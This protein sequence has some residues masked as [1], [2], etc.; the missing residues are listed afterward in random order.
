M[1]SYI[2]QMWQLAIDGQTQGIWFFAAL[3]TLIVC[4]YSLIF[5]IRTRSWPFVK[6]ELLDS[7]IKK[8][9]ATQWVQSEQD[10]IS[11]ALYKYNVSGVSYEGTKISPW[12]VVASHNAK[13]ILKKQLAAIERFVDGKIK[14]FYNPNNPKKS[15][16]LI[17][18][19]IGISI[20]F[21][22]AV[23][24]LISFYFKYQ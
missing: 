17:A 5:Q 1:I 23:L 4:S 2:E 14:V 19:K 22:I 20:T 11:K 7:G 18:G 10:Y 3:Y 16:L 8:F 21:A 6:G 13:F 15:F 9:G 24:P 12:V